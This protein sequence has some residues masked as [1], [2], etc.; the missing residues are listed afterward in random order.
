MVYILIVFG[1]YLQMMVSYFI[2]K[3]DIQRVTTLYES[4]NKNFEDFINI[5]ESV[6]GERLSDGEIDM[7]YH[8]IALYM[9]RH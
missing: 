8:I 6:T 2:F 1:K 4:F 9:H 3:E 5:F 7:R